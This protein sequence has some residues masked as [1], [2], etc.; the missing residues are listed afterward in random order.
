M[1]Y[2]LNLPL[3]GALLCGGLVAHLTLLA[4]PRG[5]D[6]GLGAAFALTFGGIFFWILVAITVLGCALAGGFEWIAAEG[7]GSR[8]M[9]VLMGFGAIALIAFLPFGIAIETAGR[10]ES[11]RWSPAT[12][13]ASRAAGLGLPILLLAYAAWLINAP[14]P[15]R[16]LPAVR[17]AALAGIGALMI[18][19]AVVS[20]QELS[21]W[22]RDSMAKMAAQR[23]VED[24]KAL[25]HR[26]AF[27]ALTDADPLLAWNQYTYHSSPDDIRLEAMRRIAARPNLDA[28]LIAVL[29]SENEN[30]AAEGVRYVAELS[31]SP[32]PALAEAVR[33]RLDAYAKQLADGAK[34]VTYDG[35]KRLDYYERSQL[36]EALAAARRLAEV[37]GADLRPQVEAL[38]RAVVLY[39]KSEMAGQFPREA[40][41]TQKYIAARLSAP[42]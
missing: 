2:L 3:L 19:G 26:R 29:A 7:T 28:E 15:D 27:E 11:A 41:E 8:F 18:A 17:F 32:S 37:P 12:I 13:W 35:D 40:A 30:W 22:N 39:P 6:A 16:A 33:Q 5:G 34:V 23:A 21:R 10:I 42:R 25:A 4:T 20:I 38:Q 36:R 1:R 24:E 14:E 31:F 9:L